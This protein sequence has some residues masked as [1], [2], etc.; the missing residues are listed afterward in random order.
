MRRRAFL[1]RSA[2][3]A[4]AA[5]AGAARA[6]T[7]AHAFAFE[8]IDGGALPLSGFAGRPVM[9]VNTASRCGFTYQY[10]GLMRVWT[11]YRDRGLIVL[12]V[13]SDDFGGQE[14]A[15]EAEVKD[16]CETNFAVDFP[17]TTITHVRG[18]KAHPF[19]R[20]ARDQLGA[21]AAPRWN[22]HKYVLD[23][24]GRLV[25]AF[26]TGT[27]PDAPAVIETIERHLPAA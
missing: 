26:G 18:P 2:A 20:W 22:F 10:D 15:S 11:R 3:L 5:L 8:S 23:G 27:E 19:Y 7:T 12:G 4:A 13:P 16:F 14:L 9:V 17:M 25:G 24:E 21:E 6:G 1:A